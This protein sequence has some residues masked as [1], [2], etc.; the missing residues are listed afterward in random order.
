MLIMQDGQ[1][2]IPLNML[3]LTETSTDKEKGPMFRTDKEWRPIPIEII[4]NLNTHFKSMQGLRSEANTQAH[5]MET[6]MLDL[7]D[8][9]RLTNNPNAIADAFE[10]LDNAR[11]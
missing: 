8:A 4:G 2:T 1:F 11:S 9:A 10:V 6:K 7:L 5:N 3:D